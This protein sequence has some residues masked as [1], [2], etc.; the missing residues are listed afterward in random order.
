MAIQA[1]LLESLHL[2]DQPIQKP[3]RPGQV[4]IAQL[5]CQLAVSTKG[6]AAHRAQAGLQ[7]I[8][9]QLL[10][11]IQTFQLLFKFF[12]AGR[13]VDLRLCFGSAF[14]RLLRRFFHTSL[15]FFPLI[16][17]ILRYLT[18]SKGLLPEDLIHQRQ[19]V[20]ARKLAAGAGAADHGCVWINKINARCVIALA[21]AGTLPPVIRIIG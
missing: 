8:L 13:F 9:H 11:K 4:I 15:L 5:F 18:Q 16:Q 14:F 21:A 1:V 10:Q 17:N 20:L 2:H 7:Q 3:L 12:D 6:H 19:T